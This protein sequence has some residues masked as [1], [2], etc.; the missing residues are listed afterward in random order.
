MKYHSGSIILK[1]DKQMGA[2]VIGDINSAVDK[3]ILKPLKILT[4]FT[5][6]SDA[7]PQKQ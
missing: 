4:I 1:E 5:F 2:M 7:F 6:G 3:Q